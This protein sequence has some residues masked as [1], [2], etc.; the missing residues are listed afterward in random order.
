MV[1]AYPPGGSIPV[2]GYVVKSF[3][4]GVSFVSKRFRIGLRG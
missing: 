2:V 3:L 1:G 4:V